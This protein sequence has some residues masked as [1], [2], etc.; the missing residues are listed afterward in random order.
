MNNRS[1]AGAVHTISI[2]L[3]WKMLSLSQGGLT[4]CLVVQFRAR[5]EAVVGFLMGDLPGK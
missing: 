3:H 2:E 4:P 5:P 1:P